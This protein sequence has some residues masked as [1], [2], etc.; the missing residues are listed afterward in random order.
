MDQGPLW[1]LWL[2]LWLWSDRQSENWPHCRP[3]LF[4]RSDSLSA[5]AVCFYC[6]AAHLR[7]YLLLVTC[8]W[9]KISVKCLSVL[10]CLSLPPPY[11]PPKIQLL[12]NPP[13]FS[14][15]VWSVLTSRVEQCWAV[16]MHGL[17][18]WKKH[19]SLLL[20]M[21]NV[22][23]RF[24]FPSLRQVHVH[25]SIVTKKTQWPRSPGQWDVAGR[26]RLLFPLLVQHV[27][28]W[29]LHTAC[30]GAAELQRPAGAHFWAEGAA[31]HLT[32]VAAG[33]SPYS[34]TERL[35]QR[36]LSFFS[37][38]SLLWCPWGRAT[39]IALPIAWRREEVLD[40]LLC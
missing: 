28:P 32:S 39:N 8:L 17:R 36:K 30:V 34:H 35:L 6:L 24:C 14:P 38:L 26:L 13:C 20:A 22:H 9:V 15:F 1:W 11:P 25:R 40:S 12:M 31:E 37:L 7:S 5:V 19:T 27:R 10:V 4:S 2:D 18:R 3:H 23:F 29:H 16:Q 33:S 21:R